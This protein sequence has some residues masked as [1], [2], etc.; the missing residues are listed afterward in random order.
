MRRPG[1]V[2]LAGHDLCSTGV[3]KAY[4]SKL[5]QCVGMK[6]AQRLQKA[7][8]EQ[9]KEAATD[10]STFG[11]CATIN[12]MVQRDRTRFRLET[13]PLAGSAPVLA[14]SV[15]VVVRSVLQR[16]YNPPHKSDGFRQEA[17]ALFKYTVC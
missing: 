14:R 2:S 11:S 9:S 4:L 12:L 17:I 5:I 6:K 16:D 10:L 8:S 13:D 1:D 7:S 3:S 15:L